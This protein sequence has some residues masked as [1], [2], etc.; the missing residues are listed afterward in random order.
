MREFETL[1]LNK[2]EKYLRTDIRYLVSGSMWL[3]VGQGVSTL[4]S[5]ATAYA[6]ANWVPKE[7]YGTYK[8]ILSIVA[9]LTIASLPDMATAIIQA[10]ARNEVGAYLAGLRAKIGWGMLGSAAACA[11]AVYYFFNENTTF[12]LIFLLIAPFV[13]LIDS[14]TLWSAYLG[15]KK[16]FKETVILNMCVQGAISLSLLLVLSITNNLFAIIAIYF[17]STAFFFFLAHKFS[18]KKHPEML[19]SG[20]AS[21]SVS[22]GKKLS[23][24]NILGTVAAQVDTFLIWHF[25]SPNQLANYAFALATTNPAKRYMKTVFSLAQP[26]FSEKDTATLKTTI[27]LKVMRS[28]LLFIP[29]TI[30]YIAVVPYVYH[31]F[32]PKYVE[33]IPYAQ[34]LGLIFLFFPFKLYST[35]LVTR[36]NK[37]ATYVLIISGSITKIVMLLISIPA[38]GIWGAIFTTLLGYAGSSLSAWYMFLREKDDTSVVPSV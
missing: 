9:I 2:A 35:A 17:A 12:A 1:I 38:F 19:L 6:F 30:A 15:G 20:D 34:A 24:I 13:P 7:T 3:S 8:Y 23:L 27:H 29:I 16:L 21:K 18:I 5:L 11:I 32:F 26:K 33:T 31:A 4:L 37:R 22:F 36:D 28:F 25:L 14:F 10:A